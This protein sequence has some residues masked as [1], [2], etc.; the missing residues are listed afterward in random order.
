MSSSEATSFLAVSHIVARM[1]ARPPF[2]DAGFD[3][4]E[5]VRGMPATD[6]VAEGENAVLVRRGEGYLMK[7]EQDPWREYR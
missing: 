7:L 5:Y 1:L 2:G 4:A 3:P 6:F